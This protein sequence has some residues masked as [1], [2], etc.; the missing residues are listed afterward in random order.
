MEQCDDKASG[1]TVCF[2]ALPFVV[3]FTTQVPFVNPGRVGDGSLWQLVVETIVFVVMMVPA[4][5]I[6]TKITIMIMMVR[7]NVIKIVVMIITLLA[8]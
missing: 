2:T 5:I 8:L 4:V 6:M 7:I 3:L 1:M